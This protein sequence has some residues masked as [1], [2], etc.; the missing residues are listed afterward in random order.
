MKKENRF[1]S[2]PAA[3]R[4]TKNEV[5]VTDD[6]E[7][8]AEKAFDTVAEQLNLAPLDDTTLNSIRSKKKGSSNSPA[9]AQH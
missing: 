3:L 5:P 4:V 7:K 9:V 2:P 1:L 6:D 8:T